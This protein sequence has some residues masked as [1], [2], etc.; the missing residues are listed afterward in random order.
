M[1]GEAFVWSMGG[2]FSLAAQLG[3]QHHLD[4]LLLALASSTDN[5]TVGLSVG[6]RRKPL[7]FWANLIISTCNA[8]GAWVAGHGG[9]LLTQPY[10]W[11]YGSS[12]ETGGNEDATKTTS[13]SAIPLYLSAIAFG[14]LA[15]AELRNYFAEKK[16]EERRRQAQAS[17]RGM[18][19]SPEDAPSST[20][21]SMINAYQVWQLA[22]PMTL[23]N[24]AGGVAGGAAGLLPEF[25]TVYAFLASFLTM[26][27]GYAMGWQ[28][29]LTL[30]Q[31]KKEPQQ[32]QEQGEEQNSNWKSP[33]HS[34]YPIF[35]PSLLSAGL[36]GLLCLLT[37][38]EAL[39]EKVA[40]PH[41]C[42]FI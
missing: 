6:I 21:R 25:S 39:I 33:L 22:I 20:A 2:T 26:A 38:Q 41:S 18:T 37:L 11:S 14:G 36:L 29:G 5:F 35:H 16:E 8:F 10:L 15:G 34:A 12:N 24:L 23:N 40:L 42:S 7:P 3:I 27:V 32:R 28:L 4:A 13:S 9:L 19:N 17:T 31:E 1:E 30:V